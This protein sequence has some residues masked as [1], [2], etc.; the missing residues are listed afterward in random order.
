MSAD[1]SIERISLTD[2]NDLME[3]EDAC[4]GIDAFSRRQM[5]YLITQSKG[6]F[7]IA[8]HNNQVA[9]YVL[10][11]TIHRHNTGRIYS[12]A[13][14]PQHR[15]NGIGELLLEKAIEFARNNALKAIFLEVRT[16]NNAA[17]SL[18]HKK[19]FVKRAL[20]LNYYEDGADGYSMVVRL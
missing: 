7:L 16:D 17:I 2:L 1:I 4:F 8:K 11:I 15:G 12:I 19:G 10:L 9:G 6:L 13:V 14:S 18:Y 5:L 20:K 3:I